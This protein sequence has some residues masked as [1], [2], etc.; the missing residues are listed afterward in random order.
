MDREADNRHKERRHDRPTAN[1]VSA[2][3]MGFSFHS[4]LFVKLKKRGAARTLNPDKT[5]SPGRN[6]FGALS[7]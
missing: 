7:P 1:A 6:V 5:P 2:A 3:S 4:V